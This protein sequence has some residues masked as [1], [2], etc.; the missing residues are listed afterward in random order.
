MRS[1]FSQRI[2]VLFAIGIGSAVSAGPILPS[3][4]ND[5]AVIQSALDAAAVSSPVGAV[6]LSAGR[7][8]LDAQLAVTNGVTLRGQGRDKTVI[9]QTAPKCRCVLLDGGS[10]LEGLALTGGNVEAESGAG[11]WVRNGVVSYCRVS[12]NAVTKGEGVFGAGVSFS[13]GR[14][15]IDHSIVADNTISTGG[16]GAGIGGRDTC[17]PIDVETCLICGNDSSGGTAGGAGF[18]GAADRVS[19][20][21]CTVAG[22]SANVGVGGFAFANGRLTLF[23]TVLARNTLNFGESNLSVAAGS[24]DTVAS[25]FCF[26]G[27]ASESDGSRIVGAQYGSPAFVDAANGDYHLRLSSELGAE[28]VSGKLTDLDDVCRSGAVDVGCYEKAT[29]PRSALLSIR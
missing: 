26:F 28:D 15:A 14:G 18:D 22:N 10:R 20:R 24:I 16:S 8:R 1:F 25:G 17:G 4:T 12:G 3:G 19:V 23:N 7:F 9:V 21:H 2:L 29:M 13:G 5:T 6:V 27:L 11:V